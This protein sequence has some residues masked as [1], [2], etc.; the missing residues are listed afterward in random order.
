M[1]ARVKETRKVVQSL[2]KKQTNMKGQH[3]FGE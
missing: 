2:K 1:V 3:V